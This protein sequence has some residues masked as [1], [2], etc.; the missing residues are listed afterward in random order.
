M[1]HVCSA[2]IL[3]VPFFPLS[4]CHASLF[5]HSVLKQLL[6]VLRE[7]DDPQGNGLLSIAGQ[8]SD[9]LMCNRRGPAALCCAAGMYAT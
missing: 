8:K 7:K 6:S 3:F 4:G 5:I 9:S 1:L 2:H